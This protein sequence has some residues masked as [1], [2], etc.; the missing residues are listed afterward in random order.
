MWFFY[1]FQL[2]LGNVRS[3]QDQRILT[4]VTDPL[5]KSL[6]ELFESAIGMKA[7][8]AGPRKSLED[9][10]TQIYRQDF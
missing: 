5:V 10:L 2:C 3:R 4:S 1:S 6:A 9:K 7:T 8:T